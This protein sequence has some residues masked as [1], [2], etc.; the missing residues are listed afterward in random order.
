MISYVSKCRMSNQIQVK[1]QLSKAEQ[2]GLT[3]VAVSWQ[4]HDSG[5]SP[6]VQAPHQILSLYN[7][8]RQ[9]VYGFVDNCTQVSWFNGLSIS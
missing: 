4:Q 1:S 8:S 5:S 6:T 7:G 9:V 3:S 2:P